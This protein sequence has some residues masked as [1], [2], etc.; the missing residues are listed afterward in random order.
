M[1]A[2]SILDFK[3]A[4][5]G[6]G[7][8]RGS[9]DHWRAFEN[10]ILS[11]EDMYPGINHW[12]HKKVTKDLATPA[13]VAYVA[14]LGHTPIASAVLKRGRSSKFC[15]VRIDDEFQDMGLGE[16]LFSL[17]ALDV[18]SVAEE[19]H[20][21]LPESLW[22][23]RRG[24]F[25][26][27][28]FTRAT[29]ASSQYRLFEQE[30]RCSASFD[31]V[32]QAAQEKLPV[33]MARSVI[34]KHEAD[35]ALLMSVRP[36]YAELILSGT[37]S[38]EIR[39]RFSPRWAGY[40]LCLYAAHPVCSVVGE[41][42][43]A[44]VIPGRPAFIWDM[45]GPKIGCTKEEFDAYVRGSEEVSA[46][47]LRDSRVYSPPLHREEIRRLSGMSLRPPQS[48]FLVEPGRPWAQALSVAEALRSRTSSGLLP[49]V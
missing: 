5:L 1:R 37:K 21:T 9:T 31:T 42:R 11:N 8:V 6:E 14:Y 20:F 12:L 23:R 48:Y 10:L 40:R 25:E 17:M 38:V 41:A 49:G 45:L 4:R 32:W 30:L 16:V 3:I 22:G 44:Q 15:H 35:G 34:D 19:I 18:R 46:I 43:I 24:F 33:L 2:P 47:V 36:R 7:D 28:G 13:R 39:R 29:I 27:F 26:S